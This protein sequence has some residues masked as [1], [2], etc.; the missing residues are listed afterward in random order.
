[1]LSTIADYTLGFVIV[2]IHL[3]RISV[4]ERHDALSR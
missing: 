2:L 4:S 1:M 3:I